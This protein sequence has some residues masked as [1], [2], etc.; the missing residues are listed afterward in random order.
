MPGDAPR[1]WEINGR[2]PDVVALVDERHAETWRELEER[3]NAVGHGAEALGLAPGDHVALIAG[4][5]AEFVEV[6]LGVQRA[7]MVVSPLKAGWTADERGWVFADAGTRL[8]VTDTEPARLAAT[9]AGIT[10][11]DLDEGYERWLDAQDRGPLPRDRAGW[12][13]SYTSGTTGRPK[14]VA[15]PGAATPWCDAFAASGMWADS[16]HLPGDGPHLMVSRL[17]H[18]APLAFALAALA[19]GAPMRIVGAWDPSTVLD[20][21]ADGIASTSMVPTMFRQLLALPQ[22]R[23][24]RFSAPA[25]R[26]IAHGGEPCPPALKRQMIDWLG[27]IFVEY[28]GFTEGGMTV[29]TTEEWEQRPGT[30]GRALPYLEIRILDDDGNA[31]GP[32][33]EGRVFFASRQGTRTFEYRNDPDKTEQAHVGDA[34]TAGDIGWVDEDGYLYISGRRADV[35][36][37]AG[38]NVY[39]AEVEA[40][41]AN[42]VGVADAAVVSAPDPE[43]GEQVAAV[44][45]LAPGANEDEVRRSITE[46]CE[47]A[48]AGYQ[49][50]RL[51]VVRG[52]LPRDPTGKLL[53]TRVRDELWAGAASA[54][55]APAPDAG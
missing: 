45:V 4:N 49:R 5:R 22:E 37:S 20:R 47:Q 35:I 3:T 54:F 24:N 8:V 15:R 28:F 51:V 31:L 50:P 25:L 53:R 19:R 39:P 26:T 29:A 36:V 40:A 1:L 27:P 48:L 41:L 17:F 42:V 9:R 21:L 10:V 30:V 2:R 11:V 12:R 46:A 55:A 43:R 7:G 18:G 52:E 33:T 32:R 34:F 6:V 44:V 23:R 14:G 13:M 38:V 16:L